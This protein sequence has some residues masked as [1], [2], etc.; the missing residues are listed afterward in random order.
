MEPL[1]HPEQDALRQQLYQAGAT[2]TQAH[3]LLPYFCREIENYRWIGL[4]F[5]VALDKVNLEANNSPVTYLRQKYAPALVMSEEELACASPDDILFAHRNRAYGAYDLRKSYHRALINALLLTLGLVLMTL[6]A[7]EAYFRGEWTYLS[8]SG[9]GWVA[10]ILLVAFAA[11]RFYIERL[12]L[13][14]ADD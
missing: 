3:A 9:G 14:L 2:P 1:S 10:G 12:T 7:T 5:G 11:F 4:P 8:L 13:R 6:S